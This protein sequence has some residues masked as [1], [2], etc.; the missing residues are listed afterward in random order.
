MASKNS[1]LA[2]LCSTHKEQ[3]GKKERRERS[4]ER[5][6]E[7]G[8]RRRSNITNITH[9]TNIY[10]ANLREFEF[11]ESARLSKISDKRSF[12]DDTLR[13]ALLNEDVSNSCSKL[14]V[15]ICF[16]IGN[17]TNEFV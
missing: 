4:G 8:G 12:Y 14:S 5:E 13:L 9:V 7:G 17:W 6:R 1:D 2:G 3:V 10:F 11:V 16:L 15:I